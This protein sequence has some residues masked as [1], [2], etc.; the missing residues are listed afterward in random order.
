MIHEENPKLQY[1]NNKLNYYIYNLGTL[2]LQ[3][4]DSIAELPLCIGNLIKLK[5]LR[6]VQISK[7][8]SF[9]MSE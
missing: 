5:C 4:C 3:N 1:Y 7:I 2:C 9:P 8:K 6:L